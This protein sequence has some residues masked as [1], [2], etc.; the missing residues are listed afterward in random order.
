[1]WREAEPLVRVLRRPLVLV[2]VAVLM[3]V[4]WRARSHAA[5][6]VGGPA[7]VQVKSSL[8]VPGAPGPAQGAAAF[9]VAAPLPDPALQRLIEGVIDRDNGTTAVVVRNLRTG[10]TAAVRDHDLL[11][12]ASLAKVPILVEVFR[13]LEAGTLKRD[14]LLTITDDSIT[15]GAGVLQARAGERL[16]VT[17]LL[18][19]SVTVS[20]NVAARLLLNAAGGPDAVNKTLAGMGLTQTRLYADDRPNTTSAAEMAALM[21][22]LATRPGPGGTPGTGLTSPAP[23]SL[24]ELLSLPQAQSWLAPGV[25]K[26]VTVAHKSGQLPGVRHDAG[27]IFAPRG[28]YVLVGLSADVADQDDAE[29]FLKRLSDAVYRYFTA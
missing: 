10:A 18:S 26:N 13:R 11:P 25:P 22:G 23:G 16:T 7:A 29:A 28:P 21:V 1:M 5:G 20:D 4:A 19:L 27:I 17:D 8:S 15:G 14:D 12:S 24:A 2:V 6:A 9:A 3:A